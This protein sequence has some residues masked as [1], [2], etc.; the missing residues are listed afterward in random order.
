MYI[1]AISSWYSLQSFEKSS[2][3]AEWQR[4]YSYIEESLLDA[5]QITQDSETDF[6]NCQNLAFI[7]VSTPI[8]T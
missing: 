2:V 5:L 8:V 3:L 7:P 6:L 4:I 1:T